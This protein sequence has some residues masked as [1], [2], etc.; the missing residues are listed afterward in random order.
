[1]P[2]AAVGHLRD[3]RLGVAPGLLGGV[4]HQRG[5]PQAE[6]ERREV[7]AQLGASP[8]SR[9]IRSATPSSGSPQKSCTSASVAATLLGRLGRAAEVEPGVA[10]VAADD[11]PRRDG[12]VGDAEVLAVEGDVLLGPQPPD[13][14]HELLGPGVAVRLVAL[15]VAVAARS[16]CPRRC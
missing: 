12:G 4:A 10:A 15:A 5:D 13:E 11:R 7:A 2:S 3:L 16:S 8:W 9:S 6:L 14:P 1:M